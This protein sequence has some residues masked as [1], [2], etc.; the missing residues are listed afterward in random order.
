MDDV[1]P[2][3]PPR[4]LID[5]KPVEGEAAPELAVVDPATGRSLATC[6]LFTDPGKVPGWAMNRATGQSLPWIF[7]GLRQQVLR[8]RYLKP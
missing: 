6:H 4:L 7:S 3:S 2:L 8:G 5:G 1:R